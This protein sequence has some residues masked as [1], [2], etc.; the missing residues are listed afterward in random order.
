MGFK[1][2]ESKLLYS[3]VKYPAGF[4]EPELLGL[5]VEDCHFYTDD[6]V[7]LHAWFVPV[8][9]AH[10]TLLYC[11]GP[12]G[13]ITH[14]I[15]HVRRLAQ[16]GLSVLIFDYRGYGRSLGKPSEL[17]L[18]RDAGAAYQFLINTGRADAQQLLIY[19]RSLGA[20]VAVHLAA[21]RKCAGLILE[22]AF[23]TIQNAVREQWPWLPVR[24]LVRSRFDAASLIPKLRSPLLVLHEK[25]DRKIAFKLGYRLFELAEEPKF[26]HGLESVASRDGLMGDMQSYFDQIHE[27][28][29]SIALPLAA[30]EHSAKSSRGDRRDEA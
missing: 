9:G 17:G 23:T 20:A 5:R 10:A 14:R 29:F 12:S 13:N 19:G 2:F 18:Y 3:P 24:W 6:R 25:K 28:I 15:D 30:L 21:R 4:W 27:F 8:R 11:H 7:R 26:F 16:M 22:S 1:F